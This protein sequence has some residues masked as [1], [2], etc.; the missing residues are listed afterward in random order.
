MDF[1]YIFW[2]FF[3]STFLIFRFWISIFRSRISDLGFAIRFSD[4]E[5]FFRDIFWNF[6]YFYNIWTIESALFFYTF[7][8]ILLQIFVAEIFHFYIWFCDTRTHRLTP[9]KITLNPPLTWKNWEIDTWYTRRYA[10]T[11]TR[12]LFFSDP[13]MLIPGDKHLHI[14]VFLLYFSKTMF[15]N[16]SLVGTN[17]SISSIKP[18]FAF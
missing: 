18:D 8:W 4:F 6:Q 3:S 16:R 9:I 17:W 5:M 10:N 2:D 1:V 7:F 13:S 11:H 15:K 12:L 14:R